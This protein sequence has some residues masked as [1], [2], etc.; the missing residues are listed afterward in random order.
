MWKLQSLTIFCCCTA[1]LK[2]EDVYILTLHYPQG[3][4]KI[5]FYSKLQLTTATDKANRGIV[6]D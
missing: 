4:F 5:S 1:G 6:G 2:T 3:W